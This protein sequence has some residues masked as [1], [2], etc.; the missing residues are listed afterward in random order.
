MDNSIDV[1]T[2]LQTLGLFV[3][4]LF[5]IC[6]IGLLKDELGL[7]DTVKTM[8]NLWKSFNRRLNSTKIAT[9]VSKPD[10][11]ELRVLSRLQTYFKQPGHSHTVTQHSRCIEFQNWDCDIYGDLY[12]ITDKG[13]LA[14]LAKLLNDNGFSI[15]YQAN[16]MCGG[17]CWDIWKPTG[18]EK[19]AFLYFP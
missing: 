14:I 11:S 19:P 1:F 18:N 8:A 15:S 4:P 9:K 17:K 13:R 3:V 6:L 7:N 10:E 2:K 12:L 16:D 5:A